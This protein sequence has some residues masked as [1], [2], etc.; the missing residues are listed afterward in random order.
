MDEAGPYHFD[1]LSGTPGNPC[2]ILV[3]TPTDIALRPAACDLIH[4][5]DPFRMGSKARHAG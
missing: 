1:W 2:S 5:E 3:A 4:H